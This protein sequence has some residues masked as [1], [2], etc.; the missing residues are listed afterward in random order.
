VQTSRGNWTLKRRLRSA[1]M[2][3]MMASVAVVAEAAVQAPAQALP[4]YAARQDALMA[5]YRAALAQV[6]DGA[7]DDAYSTLTKLIE[8]GDF[9]L[10]SSDARGDIFNLAAGIDFYHKHY[11]LAQRYIH[12]AELNLPTDPVILRLAFKIE[13]AQ[14]DV[15]AATAVLERLDG[16]E[17]A[18][19]GNSE[20]GQVFRAAKPEQ[21][22]RFLEALY[23]AQW[24][25][26][27]GDEPSV[28]WLRLRYER[29]RAGDLDGAA[30]VATKITNPKDR[31]VLQ[32]DRRFQP[33]KAA[34]E[35]AKSLLATGEANLAVLRQRAEAQPRS[36]DAINQIGAALVD[37]G[38]SEEA[39]MLADQTV[40]R[41]K[42]ADSSPFDDVEQEKV[43]TLNLRSQALLD[44][45]RID[46]A[47]QQLEDAIALTERGHSTVSQVINLAQLYVRLGEADKAEAV[48]MQV[49]ST[50]DYGQ[51]QVLYVSAYVALLRGDR[52]RYLNVVADLEKL[53]EVAP[54]AW[55]SVQLRAGEND[56]V[57]AR[58]VQWLGD[59]DPARVW[60]ALG[61]LAADTPAM[62]GLPAT[63]Q[64]RAQLA[65]IRQRPE[66]IAAVAKVGR[67][68]TYPL[69]APLD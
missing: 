18:K 50:S 30:E 40:A 25:Y 8:A 9:E 42:A 57:A 14:Q 67:L 29:V 38:R 28:Y 2:A 5:Q 39:L 41:L 10:L 61:L 52:E 64:Q 24:K 43:W 34:N 53:I 4:G 56:A 60:C 11:V 62:P 44:V 23:R 55:L 22:H 13:S 63:E 68:L 49:G 48:I 7:Y 45:G 58:L 6:D 3:L 12:L 1:L 54:R 19:L 26:P 59:P 27:T 65:A 37:L 36:L 17:A 32:L 69:P 21:M 20:I 33:L 51:A 15:V 16:D 31:L 66:I 47:V 46:E 35:D